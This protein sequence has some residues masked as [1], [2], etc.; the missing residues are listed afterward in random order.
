MLPI[1]IRMMVSADCSPY[2]SF[3]RGLNEEL[4]TDPYLITYA[5]TDAK[6]EIVADSSGYFSFD[7]SSAG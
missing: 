4:S 2:I 6:V 1:L 5:N 3:L 7:T